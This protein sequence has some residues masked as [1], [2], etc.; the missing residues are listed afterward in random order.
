MIT[1]SEY[2]QLF[3][4]FRQVEERFY[5]VDKIAEKLG[6]EGAASLDA[7]EN[8]LI[9]KLNELDEFKNS[10]KFQ[11]NGEIKEL[12]NLIDRLSDEAAAIES[13]GTEI[14]QSGMEVESSCSDFEYTIGDINAVIKGIENSIDKTQD[15]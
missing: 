8:T 11:W 1:T 12:N 14:K 5:F 10:N 15:H 9:E 2:D 3:R 7:I 6:F 13:Y 4:F